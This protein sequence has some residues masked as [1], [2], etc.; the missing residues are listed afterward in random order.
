MRA[1]YKRELKA[2]L[3]SFVGWLF[4]AVVLFLTGL[5]TTVY[6]LLQGSVYLTDTLVS[7]RILFM[8]AIPVLTMRI[9][10]E[11]RKNRTDQMILTA[12]VS[13]WKVVLG[14]FLAL[15]T[16]FAV[17]C[18]I[19]CL[20]P[21]LFGRYGT[22]P[23]V[24]NYVGLLGF[25][26]YGSAA[27]AIGVFVSSLTESQVIAAVLTV[28]FVFVGSV[29]S[30]ICSLLSGSGNLL[31]KIL[32]LYDLSTP[33]VDLLNG[34]L[35][36]SAVAYY[37]SVIFLFLFFTVQSIQKRRYSVSV[38]QLKR[39]AYSIGMIILTTA[40]VICGNLLLGKI[41]TEYTEFDVTKERLYSLTEASYRVMDGLREDI[42]IYVL[43][44]E[45][46]MSKDVVQT[47][48]RYEGYSKGQI[49]VEYVDIAENPTFAS[50]YTDAPLSAGSLIV[51]SGKRS[52]CIDYEALYQTQLSY[53]TFAYQTTG[54]DAEGQITSAL[55]Y[56]TMEDMP[57]IYL[58][59]GHGEAELEEGFL[60][61][62]SKLNIEYET[63]NLLTTEGVPEDAAGLLVNAPAT[64]LSKDDAQKIRAYLESGKDALFVYGYSKE[65]LPNYRALLGEYQV[66]I[67]DGLVVE[68][69]RNYYYQDNIL[70]LLPEVVYD[71]FTASVYGK[72]VF[73]PNACGILMEEGPRESGEVHDLLTTT[74]EAFVRAD[75]DE[76]TAGERLE[77]DMAGPFALGVRATRQVAGG[78]STILVYTSAELFSEVVDERVSGNNR[79]LFE[80]AVRGFA[81]L[82]DAVSIPV[83]NYYAGLLTVP[84]ADVL[85]L[86]LTIVLAVPIALL[87]VG[88]VIWMQRR[89][90]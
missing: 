32:E 2:C 52:K 70:W 34:N 14:K 84:M 31:T 82:E 65:E 13:I 44:T 35:K 88:F 6:N 67:A 73:A 42:T 46:G 25:F 59:A 4:L 71:E 45:S 37:L 15:E 18:L 8:I 48:K 11:E 39:G 1:I 23:Y 74:A 5:Y 3:N 21:P 29:M 72:Y 27:I 58:L 17:P 62:L 57:K 89:R 19:L 60:S 75:P 78:E 56:V 50:E 54:Y 66:K 53:D 80:D 76:V 87:L 81:S 61:V 83:K 7:C 36:L 64:D 51:V 12:P 16:V 79:K 69:D 30:G 85:I 20:Y 33:F 90:R 24:E 10:A 40:L 47:L 22:I 77:E 49:Q 55:H 63:L 9:L 41:P 26:L 28:V 86:G 43:S 68:Q 38:R